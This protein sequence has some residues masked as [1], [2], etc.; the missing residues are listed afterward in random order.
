MSKYDF[1]KVE[2]PKKESKD[3]ITPGDSNQKVAHAQPKKVPKPDLTPKEQKTQINR[4]IDLN[5]IDNKINE[6]VNDRILKL[7]K[8]GLKHELTIENMIQYFKETKRLKLYNLTRYFSDASPG[9]I[10]QMLQFLYTTK[11][12]RKD[13]NGWYWIKKVN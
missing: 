11:V 3:K 4:S 13:R 7:V 8:L 10:D 12:L 5:M 2:E 6:I 1:F 9:K